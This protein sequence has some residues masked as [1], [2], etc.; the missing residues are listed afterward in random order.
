[1]PERV[2]VQEV[3]NNVHAHRR[4]ADLIR[5]FSTNRNDVRRVAVEALDLKGCRSILDVGC[6]FGSFAKS[7]RGRVQP[8]ATMTGVDVIG[9]YEPLFLDACRHAG[10]HGRFFPGGV[11]VIK[12]FPDRS[13][14][15]VLCSY[16]LYFFPEAVGD[17][18]RLL[19]PEGTF[20]AITHH[21]NNAGELIELTKDVLRT[22]GIY[23]EKE[24]PF[25]TIVGR[26]SSENGEALLNPWFGEISTI[27]YRNSLVFPPADVPH[28]LE[29]FRFKSPLY[30]M[31]T[32]M[33]EETLLSRIRDRLIRL[34]AGENGLT[35]S[36]DDRI[37]ICRSPGQGVKR[38]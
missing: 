4:I 12:T 30:L 21:R 19:V 37:F 6:A 22:A 15:L 1:M 2:R 11:S 26:F 27:D 24:L 33:D 16:A 34:S 35:V 28:L 18:A 3:F 31:G 20:I 29:Y 23:D 14:D 36:K 32:G 8:D 9:A 7:L 10:M 38:I 25:E 5:R 13:F 17:I